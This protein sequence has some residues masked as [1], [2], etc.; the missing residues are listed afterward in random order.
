MLKM[1]ILFDNVDLNSSSGPNSFAR[2]LESEL[3]KDHEICINLDEN[4]LP[5][6]QLSFIAAYYKC[7]PIVQRLD[8]I[9]FNTEQDWESLNLPIKQ[10]YNAAD[11][12][13][14]QSKFNKTLTEN[15]FGEHKNSSVISNGTL[16]STIESIS[17]MENEILDNFE[18]VWVCASTWRPHK[19]LSENIRYFMEKA[20]Q[21]DCLVICGRDPDIKISHPR[22]FY[23]GQLMWKDLISLYRR[24]SHFIHLAFLD[25]CPNVV[26][27]ARA[28]GCKIVCAS[29][30]GTWE[31]S[32]DNSVIIQDLEWDFSPIKLYEPPPLD[33]GSYVI[34]DKPEVDISISGVA[35]K[36]CQVLQDVLT[37]SRG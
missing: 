27:D 36:Y 24:A 25:H 9:Y 21:Y 19:R 18:N 15:F 6:V 32:G 7:A 16:T 17:P 35:Q 3:K 10:T 5:E 33:F 29:S 23:A 11:A 2:K 30:G 20:A 1:K 26:V 28:A 34:N 37:N 13:I 8:G 4:F 12:V 22:V 14:F 31:I